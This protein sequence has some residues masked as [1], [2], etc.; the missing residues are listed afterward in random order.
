MAYVWIVETSG[1]KTFKDD[2]TVAP[3]RM[4]GE[5]LSVCRAADKCH[6]EPAGNY[7]CIFCKDVGCGTCEQ[8]PEDN[9]C[10]VCGASSNGKCV[11]DAI[12]DER[13]G[14]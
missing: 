8:E 5:Y 12:E 13:T 7:F 3:C 9:G 4:C 10:V 14:N 1:K 6:E 11:C 2:R